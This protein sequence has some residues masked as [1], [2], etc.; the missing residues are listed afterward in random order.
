MKKVV[1]LGN[2]DAREA[3]SRDL[4]ELKQAFSDQAVRTIGVAF[5]SVGEELCLY[6]LSDQ[7]RFAREQQ[8]HQENVDAYILLDVDS[9][10]RMA[11]RRPIYL[12]ANY[13]SLTALFEHIQQ[14]PS[15]T[16]ALALREH[17]LESHESAAAALRG[18]SE[19]QTRFAEARQFD[20]HNVTAPAFHG[21]ASL[22]GKFSAI[23]TGNAQPAPV[24]LKTLE[25]SD[26]GGPAD[27]PSLGSSSE[28]DE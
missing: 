16:E 7:A 21:L 26:D 25:H 23:F 10:E 18:D 24:A 1:V 8:I 28:G 5:A 17:D 14:Q 13:D 9:A 20:E 27:R 2:R 6:I 4:I 12:S 3:F 19:Q 15:Y 22:L 11:H